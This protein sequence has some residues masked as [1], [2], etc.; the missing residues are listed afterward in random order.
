MED[1]FKE[2]IPIYKQKVRIKQLKR[3]TIEN[4]SRF[5]SS[6]VD[7]YSDPADKK[8][9]K[10]K[11]LHVKSIG[12]QYILDNQDLIYSEINK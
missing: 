2:L 10:D 4:F 11:Y 12:L 1:F 8:Q 3:K 6:F 7:Q 9:K 5:Y